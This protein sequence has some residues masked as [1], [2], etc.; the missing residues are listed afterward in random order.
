M[1]QSSSS[2]S[3]G[4]NYDTTE[5][6]PYPEDEALSH[7]GS[8]MMQELLD[9][10]LNTPLED[11]LLIAEG[12]LGG[13]HTAAQR[14]ERSADKAR[15]DMNRGVREF[16]GSEVAD[17]ELQEATAKARAC[18]AAL[19]AVEKIRDAAAM[20]YTVATGEVWS[21]WKGYVRGSATTAALMDAK[22][23]LRSNKAA[24][25]AATTP[26]AVLVAFRASPQAV[27]QTDANR[28]FDALNWAQQT[29]PTMALITT[30]LKGAEKIAMRWAQQ[31]RVTIVLAKADFM[32]KR[33]AEQKAHVAAAA[34]TQANI[35]PPG[36][37]IFVSRE[38]ALA[39]SPRVAIDTPALQG[40]IALKGGRLDDLFLKD[41][42]ETLAKTSPP[43]ELLRPEGAK[44]AYFSD[45]GWTG[46]IQSPGPLTVWTQ[47]SQGPLSP[48][49]PVILN[50]DNGQGLLFT[51]SIAVD[52]RYMFTVTNTVANKGAAPVQL[53]AYASVQ[54]QGIPTLTPNWLVNEGAI[55]S[56]NGILK[57]IA[58]KNWKKN[59]DQ[60]GPSTGGYMG[61]T[62][63]YWLAAVVPAPKE[64]VKGEFKVSTVNG[65]DVY[66][67]DY[68]G[69]PRTLAPGAQ[70]SE[71][72][73]VFAGAKKVAILQDYQKALSIPHF[74]DAVDWG[75]LWFLTRPMFFV[76]E[77]FFHL[78]GNFGLAILG[79]TVVVKAL[80]FPLAN[81]SY[82]SMS[83]MK[84]LQPEIEGIKKRFPEDAM[85]Q[86]QETMALYKKEQ[87]NPLAGC[88]TM[89]PTI[90]V[91]Y[92]LYTVLTVTLEMRQAPFFGWI[93]DLSAPDPTTFVNLF[94]L[95][96]W[97]P[98]A[99]PLIGGILDGPLHLGVWPLALRLR[100]VAL[101]GR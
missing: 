33:E 5:G 84:K 43:V 80:M 36:S 99:T 56:L 31:K 81:K 26:G 46:P 62:D 54:R 101:H 59:G 63:K 30:G 38:Q 73:H 90:P 44:D 34:S 22:D 48:S 47:T 92:S 14:I 20:A 50:W 19:E 10:M 68:V 66:E 28:I 71:T 24:R 45:S 75:W 49:H 13:L 3:T 9:V 21:P 2:L 41:Y 40:S 32:K 60:S 6:R 69:S 4:Y 17:T 42:R 87:I 77:L 7:V 85:K 11:H 52:A 83:K 39:G 88:I 93:H 94:G 86:Q 8:A 15:D 12:I 51:R 96:P 61:I 98:G 74:D 78:F 79:L 27:S 57:Q 18:D 29:Y 95:I 72:T 55:G 58:F 53:A 23:A 64:D 37:A 89:L 97:A 82:E 76:L 35:A 91:F 16:D 1:Q 25:H 67:A 70:T 65:A 100:H